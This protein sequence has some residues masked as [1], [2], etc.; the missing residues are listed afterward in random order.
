MIVLVADARAQWT[1]LDRRISTFDAE[2]VRWVKENVKR[3]SLSS[4]T[5]GGLSKKIRVT[6]RRVGGPFCRQRY[7]FTEST[8][9]CPAGPSGFAVQ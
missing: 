3:A 7:S 8:M 2:F 4:S 6:S 9:N 5:I 1:E